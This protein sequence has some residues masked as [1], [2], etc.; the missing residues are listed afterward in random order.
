MP[1]VRDSCGRQI[2]IR[3]ILR[4]LLTMVLNDTKLVSIKKAGL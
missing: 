3:K 2:L 1:K 4:I